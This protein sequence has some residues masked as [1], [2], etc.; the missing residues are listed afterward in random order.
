MWYDLIVLGILLVAAYRG[1]QRGVI[2]QV[3]AIASVVLC[4]VFSEVV[5]AVV[6]PAIP[7]NP[8]VNY[9]VAMVVAFIGLSF[10]SFGTARVLDSAVEKARMKEFNRHLGAAFGLVK[11]VAFCLVLTFFLVT[12]SP[13]AREALAGSRSARYAAVIM[14]KIHPVMPEKLQ[15]AL[16]KY[17][18]E[19]NRFG[20][21]PVSVADGFGTDDVD[22]GD[23]GLGDFT[24]FGDDF[25]SRPRQP[26]PQTNDSWN[27]WGNSSA[28]NASSGGRPTLDA[29]TGMTDSRNGGRGFGG[30]TANDPFGQPAP[31]QDPYSVDDIIARLPYTV[32]GEAERYLRGVL[33]QAPNA[34]RPAL[35]QRL[36]E[37]GPAAMGNVARSYLNGRFGRPNGQP[38]ANQPSAGQVARDF[39]G[40]AASDAFDSRYG[41]NPNAVQTRDTLSQAARDL[42]DRRQNAQQ[43]RPIQD[44]A[45]DVMTDIATDLLNRRMGGQQQPQQFGQQQPQQNSQPD[46]RG[47]IGNAA[48]QFFGGNTPAAPAGGISG[49]A[50][51]FSDN[52]QTRQDVEQQLTQKLQGLPA[53]VSAAVIADWTADRRPGLVD[54]EPST[55][56]STPFEDRLR[57]AQQRTQRT[58][59][60]GGLRSLFE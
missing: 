1:L 59:L 2:F 11:G 23:A 49:L 42:Y 19:A 37:G 32:T 51:T 28:D 6:A 9:W 40:G 54:P 20:V 31:A 10:L 25:M 50:A 14:H 60:G 15:I 3:A 41:D 4:F 33:N 45:R 52:P 36:R 7:L 16:E 29:P 17:I 13:K 12:M 34:D 18:N 21:Q 39:I 30:N 48:G 38:A 44:D 47:M 24:S 46:Y 56:K 35:E 8:P 27:P 43:S 22:L 57:R 53:A 5:S 58:Q 55:D 26:A